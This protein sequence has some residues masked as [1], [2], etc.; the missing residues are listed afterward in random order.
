MT[1]RIAETLIIAARMIK[2]VLIP[3][4]VRDMEYLENKYTLLS[5]LVNCFTTL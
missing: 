5:D 2:P 3:A 4:R 1:N